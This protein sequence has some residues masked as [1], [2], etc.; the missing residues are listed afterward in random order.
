MIIKVTS[1]DSNRSLDGVSGMTKKQGLL[2]I[3][4]A[5]TMAATVDYGIFVVWGL[6]YLTGFMQSADFEYHNLD[7]TLVINHYQFV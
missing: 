7:N 2:G 1:W 3:I 4:I 5:L 6:L